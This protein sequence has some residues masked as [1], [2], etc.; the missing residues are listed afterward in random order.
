M[1]LGNQLNQVKITLF[2]FG[3]KG[4]VVADIINFWFF[5]KAGMP[6]DISFNTDNGFN[7]DRFCFLIK[8][9]RAVE[10]AVIGDGER[11]HPEFFGA[12]NQ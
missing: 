7:A 1:G 2:V 9:N 10:I 3:K 12:K 8:F 5:G 4:E 6:S 11:F